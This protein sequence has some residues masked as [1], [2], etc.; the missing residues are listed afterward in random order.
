M[1]FGNYQKALQDFLKFFTYVNDNCEIYN[2]AG[3]CYR[4]L[5]NPQE[6]VKFIT[7]AISIEQR[8]EF[9]VNRANSYK[10]FDLAAAKKD[11]VTAKSKGYPIPEDL[12]KAVGM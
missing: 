4:Q 12:S 3:T 2:F 8:G 9:Y 1:M 10:L 11:V 6:S 7:K 5:G